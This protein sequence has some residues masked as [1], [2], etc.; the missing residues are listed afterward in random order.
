MLYL[1]GRT[2]YGVE[3]F[4]LRKTIARWFFM[5]AVTGRFTGSPETA[6]EFD[7]AGLRDTTEADQFVSRLQQVCEVALTSD[8]WSV[9]LPNDLA[10]SSPRS[11][12]LFAYNA[13]LVLLDAPVLF[14]TAKVAEQLDPVTQASRSMIERH[15][16]FPKGHLAAVGI[17]ATRDTN[18]IANYAYLEW[19]DNV[20]ISDQTP[21]EYLPQLKHRF[22]AAELARMYQCH[23]LPE[24]WELMEYRV[25]LEKRREMMAQ[26]VHQGYLKLTGGLAPPPELGELDLTAVIDQGESDAVE[27][28][29]TLR[30][31]LHTGAADKRM[32]QAVLKTM[33]G[34]LNA[35]GGA[36]IVGVSD[37]GTPVGIDADKFPNEDKMSLH[38]VN[39][40]KT[41]M[42]AGAMTSMHVRFED[43]DDCRVLIVRCL[44][45]PTPVYVKEGEAERFYVRTGPS[46]TELT[47]SQIPSYVMHRFKVV[48]P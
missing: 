37:A 11:P 7:L 2:E 1:I 6:M 18:Q 21:A 22:G 13:A 4:T 24:D 20:K 33:A 12:S 10:T 45:S 3:E 26:V 8:F 42:G 47:A 43:Y 32:E 9:T 17:S 27:F 34:F 28:K 40:V 30:M 14:S 39:I 31:N 46:T 48:T 44:R 38:L 25:F 19:T 35:N 41:R 23:A 16:L 15:H 29:S 5:S 36:L